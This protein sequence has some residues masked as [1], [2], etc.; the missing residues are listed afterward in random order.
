[1]SVKVEPEPEGLGPPEN[2]CICRTPTHTWFQPRRPGKAVA[3]C[4]RC[5]YFCQPADIPTKKQWCRRERIA[6]QTSL[7]QIQELSATP[8]F[9]RIVLGCKVQK[10]SPS[11]SVRDC[12]QALRDFVLSRYGASEGACLRNRP[13]FRARL[14]TGKWA[15]GSTEMEAIATWAKYPE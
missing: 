4:H 10:L 15:Y 6:M 13:V 9:R 8:A 11:T 1:M 7:P 3:L 2:C 5:A 14:G 12:E